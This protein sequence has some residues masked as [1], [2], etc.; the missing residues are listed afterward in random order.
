M[1]IFLKIPVNDIFYKFSD[2]FII[3]NIINN[4]NM[5]YLQIADIGYIKATCILED[6][7]RIVQLNTNY[8]IICTTI[9]K[10]NDWKCNTSS[11]DC[12]YTISLLYSQNQLSCDCPGRCR[13]LYTL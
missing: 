5:N 12:K 2:D 10:L 8:N 11:D 3:Y 6:I 9:L 4:N 13:F 1:V 7:L